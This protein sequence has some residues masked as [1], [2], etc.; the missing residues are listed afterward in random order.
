MSVYDSAVDAVLDL[1]RNEAHG[2]DDLF[3]DL[4]ETDPVL[5]GSVPDLPDWDKRTKLAFE[6]EM[7]G[8]YVSDHPLQGLDHVLAAERD[9]GIGQLL[10]EDGPREGQVTIA[11]MI[12]NVT[13]KTTRRGDIWAV[14]TVEDLEA[15]IEVLLFP[16][17]YD[18]VATVLA[19]DIVVKVKGRVKADDDSVTVNASELTLPD[20]S[21]A[22]T[23]PVVISLPAVRCTPAVLDQLRDVL[24]HHPGMTE[25]RIRL[26]KPERHPGRPAAPASGDAIAAADGRPQGSAGTVVSG[27]LARAVAFVLLGLGLGAAA[28]VV[29]WAV[30]D[31]PAM[32]SIL[33]GGASISERGLTEFL[34]GDAWF[35]AIGLVVGT[36]IGIG[37]WRWFRDLGWPLVLGVCG[38]AVAASWS[39]GSSATAWARGS[40]RRG[41]RRPGQA[42]WCRS[43]SPCGPRRRCWS[44]RSRPWC[45]CCSAPP[46]AATTRSRDR[47]C[48]EV[49]ASQLRH[50]TAGERLG[51]KRT[52]HGAGQPDQL[53]RCQLDLE[54]A[55]A[56]GDED[57]VE[58]AGRCVNES[59]QPGPLA[60]RRDAADDVAGGPGRGRRIGHA[61]PLWPRL[62][63]PAPS[64]PAGGPPATTATT[65]S[66]PASTTR[67]LKIRSRSTPSAAAASSPKL[68]R[69][70]AVGVRVQAEGDPRAGS[71]RWSPA[72]H[73]PT[74]LA[75][76][77]PAGAGRSPR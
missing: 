36:L 31:L 74:L 71:M 69:A 23:G 37:G 2:Q 45:R 3:G 40:S 25:V 57:R 9:V 11:G 43:S 32:W 6:R 46:S 64:G 28:G 24:A 73:R 39:A 63:Q 77:S 17:A 67:V 53:L 4:A 47:C 27:V 14:I 12:T 35:C 18:A 48:D 56:S 70:V 72:S 13:R 38:L 30:V 16:K 62:R 26:L 55:P 65:S 61:R 20:V 68:L 5:T 52:H 19:T 49:R 76:R 29:W 8:L 22:P 15:S 66:P 41:W 10:A 54:P 21:E 60:Q 58:V 51:T 59:A 33:D 7:L 1:K 44:G 42:T 50:P 34:A 75:I